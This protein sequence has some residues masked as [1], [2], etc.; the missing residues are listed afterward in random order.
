MPVGQQQHH[1]I[2]NAAGVC[3]AL[4]NWHRIQRRPVC[5]I[6]SRGQVVRKLAGKSSTSEVAVA[7]NELP[8]NRLRPFRLVAIIPTE[9]SLTEW[10]GD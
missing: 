5:S 8:L 9:K 4:I 7:L 3:L 2:A 1:K 6:M 10:N